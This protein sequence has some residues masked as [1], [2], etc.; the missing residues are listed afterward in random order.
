[1]PTLHYGTGSSIGFDFGDRAEP[2]HCGLP[3][4]EPLGDVSAAVS[5]A[6]AEPLDFPPLDVIWTSILPNLP[7]F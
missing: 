6:M 7:V 5:A 3:R 2:A 4:G 1:M